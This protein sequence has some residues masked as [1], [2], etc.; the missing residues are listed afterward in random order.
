MKYGQ[1]GAFESLARRMLTFGNGM[2][3][4]SKK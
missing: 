3:C 1:F 4:G 2:K